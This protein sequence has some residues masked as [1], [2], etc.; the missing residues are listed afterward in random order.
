M[1]CVFILHFLLLDIELLNNYDNLICSAFK[2]KQN[3]DL[4]NRTE[5]ET[6]VSQL[7][8]F[9]RTPRCFSNIEDL[10]VSIRC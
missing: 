3:P 8:G 9:L 4:E 6:L 7:L 10:F 5:V 2:H 1:L